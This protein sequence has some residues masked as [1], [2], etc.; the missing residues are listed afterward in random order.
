[1]GEEVTSEVLKNPGALL[2]AVG[3]FVTTAAVIWRK[4]ARSEKV[5]EANTAAEVGQV[6]RLQKLLSDSDT[7]YTALFA[8]LES[9][10]KR[11]DAAFDERNEMMKQMGGLQQKIDGLT[12]EV[13]RLNTEIATLRK[14][15]P[16]GN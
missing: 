5:S 10:R 16:N 9:E 3:G 4:W 6:E 15:I 7:R 14:T 2:A 1:M 8:V 13:D 11:A 12:R